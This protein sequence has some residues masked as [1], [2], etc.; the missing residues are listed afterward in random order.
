MLKFVLEN[1]KGEATKKP[2]LKNSYLTI[3][4]GTSAY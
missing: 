1:V 2:R 3:N 4:T